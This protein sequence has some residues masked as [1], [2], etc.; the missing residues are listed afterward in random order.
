MEYTKHSRPHDGTNSGV[1]AQ[2]WSLPTTTIYDY[3]L[4]R[5]LPTTTCNCL[6]PPTT[7]LAE[8]RRTAAHAGDSTPRRAR[9]RREGATWQAALRYS[10][11]KISALHS[12]RVHDGFSIFSHTGF[13]E[14]SEL[15][16]HPRFD[17]NTHHALLGL[18]I[19]D[20]R[21]KYT[22]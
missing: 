18:H 10:D 17:C 20:I 2:H 3:H 12:N 9:R 7:T 16:S 1:S 15:E 13:W 5:L 8:R 4:L 21:L 11:S 6:R 22:S 19:P 14:F